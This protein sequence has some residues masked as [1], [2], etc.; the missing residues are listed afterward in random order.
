M[1]KPT[2]WSV[3]VIALVGCVAVGAALG[4]AALALGWCPPGL[5]A[6]LGAWIAIGVVLLAGLLAR[7]LRRG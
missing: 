2:L 4:V 3:D 5:G 1:Q 7:H 6:W